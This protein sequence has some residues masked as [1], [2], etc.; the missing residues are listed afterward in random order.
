MIN[1]TIPVVLWTAFAATASAEELKDPRTRDDDIS[2]TRVEVSVQRL[3]SGFYDYIYSLVTPSE[4][5]GTLTDLIVDIS[6]AEGP[7]AYEFPEPE[8][9]LRWD[10]AGARH[11]PVQIY[12][13]PTGSSSMM[14]GNDDRVHFSTFMVP[15]EAHTGFRILSPFP[16]AD[17]GYEL[18]AHWTTGDYDYSNLTDEEWDQ[19]PTR[20][21][22]WVSGMTKGP[23][24]SNEPEPP[25]LFPGS[26]N[27]PDEHLLQYASP[28]QSAFHA[29][30]DTVTFDIHYA[31]DLIADSFQVEPAWARRLFDP[32]P[33]GH[34]VVELKLH[35]GMNRFQIRGE[36]TLREGESGG[37][38]KPVDGDLFMI[39]R[40]APGQR[41]GGGMQNGARGVRQ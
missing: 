29:E 33:G 2:H 16:P 12:P 30:G 7:A 35:P 20:D 19:L 5:K 23:G 4:N 40:S 14:I 28:M 1:R 41:A 27:H 11:A 39:R 22:F 32:V 10:Y 24:C 37:K 21:E 26:G 15:V 9:T 3:P 38:F 36:R 17:R 8:T 25:A 13:S 18:R 31:E 6:C 34:Q